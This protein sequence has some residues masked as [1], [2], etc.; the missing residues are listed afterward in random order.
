MRCG[1]FSFK[2]SS[3]GFAQTSQGRTTLS[4]APKLSYNKKR[5][6]FPVPCNCSMVPSASPPQLRWRWRH[7]T[8]VRM[9]GKA[10]L[11]SLR[12]ETG[13]RRKR[14]ART[15]HRRD[16]TKQSCRVGSGGVN[17]A[18]SLLVAYIY[19][20]NIICALVTPTL[21][22]LDLCRLYSNRKAIGVFYYVVRLNG[23]T[24]QQSQTERNHCL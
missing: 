4:I 18:L 6:L 20:T 17:W 3:A 22:A 13:K 24:L 21:N 5:T 19:S 2:P 15:S 12:T 8:R 14:Y 23:Q 7:W 9:R 16:A 10:S 11:Y 1:E